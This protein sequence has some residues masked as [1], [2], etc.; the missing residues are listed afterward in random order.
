MFNLKMVDTVGGGIRKIFNF[1]RSRFFPLPDYDPRDGKVRVKLT[2]KILN[3]EYTRGLAT[4]TDLRLE[5][6]ILLDKVQKKIPL[7]NEEEKHLKGK[8]LI[9][10]R[11]PNFIISQNVAEKIGKKAEYSKNKGLDDAYYLDFVEKSIREHGYLNRKDIDELL[12]KKL[13]E[14]MNDKQ[15]KNKI[16]NLLSNLRNFSNNFSRPL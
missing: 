11:K 6:I 1:Q 4:N 8:G 15:K 7:N 9:E 3:Q 5:E 13:Q 10:G 16:N 14:W 12:W 2:G